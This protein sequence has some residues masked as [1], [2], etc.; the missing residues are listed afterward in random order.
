[1]M[2][3]EKSKTIGGK[4]RYTHSFIDGMDSADVIKDNCIY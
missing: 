3:V 1:M 4:I 2:E